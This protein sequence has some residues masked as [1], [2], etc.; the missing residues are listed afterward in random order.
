MR[1]VNL[2]NCGLKVSEVCI[3]TW[4]LPRLMLK[5]AYGIPK[6]DVEETKKMIKIAFD[7]GVNFID[8]ANRYHGAMAPVDKQHWGNAERVL[9]EILRDHERESFVLAT[10]V[11][12]QMA[13][14]PNGQG[15]SRKH[16]FWQINESLRRLQTEYVDIYL[17]HVPDE[18]TP[19]LETLIAFNDLIRA[20]KVHYIGSSNLSPADVEDFMGLSKKH[21]LASF[22]TLQEAYN[23]FNRAIENDK[24]PLA[25][26][27]NFAV[28]AY[29]PLAQG[30]LSG[31]Y[32]SGIPQGS[33]ATYYSGLKEALTEERL[34]AV[35]GLDEI[36]KEKQITLSQLAISWILHKQRHLGVKIIPILGVSSSEQLLENLQ[37]L[38]VQLSD[39]EVKR[40]EDLTSV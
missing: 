40:A 16:I 1:Y 6:V 20:G 26:K 12:G 31:K 37:A 30:L 28:M 24:V 7:K 15:L 35:K 5:D 11:G 25:R 22:V 18:E 8:T 4:H 29:S 39:D 17:I 32:L 27:Y 23:L 36:A 19:H 14:W 3:G 33:R 9:G 10:K 34:K 38:D 13:P 2:G 21:K